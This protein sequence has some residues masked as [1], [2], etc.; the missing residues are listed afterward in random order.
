MLDEEFSRTEFKELFDAIMEGNREKGKFIANAL[1]EQ[2]INLKDA[3]LEGVMRTVVR[4]GNML[5]SKNPEDVKKWSECLITIYDVLNIFNKNIKPSEKPVGKI[6]LACLKGEGHAIVKDILAPAFRA[7]GFEV[8]NFRSPA[9]PQQIMEKIKETKAD[10]LAIS[11]SMRTMI[12]E[13]K[14]LDQALKTAG[15]REKIKILVGG[16]LVR[17]TFFEELKPDLDAWAKDASEGVEIAKS[18]AQQA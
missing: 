15:L 13:I 3:L 6:I 5:S 9:T 14:N 16:W 12:D 10:I 17:R 2:Q 11:A 1:V 18:L 4:L 8:Y 7:E